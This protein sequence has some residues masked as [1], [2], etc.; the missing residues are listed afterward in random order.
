MIK[1]EDVNVLAFAN[2][3]IFRMSCSSFRLRIIDPEHINSMACV[4]I[5]RKARSSWLIPSVIVIRPNWLNVEE[6]CDFF[7]VILLECTDCCK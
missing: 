6:C 2:P 7:D 5:C 1:H 4:Q 3:P